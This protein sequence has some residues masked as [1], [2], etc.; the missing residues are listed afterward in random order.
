M[1][2]LLW[3]LDAVSFRGPELSW[4]KKTIHSGCWLLRWFEHLLYKFLNRTNR[5]KIPK[6]KHI[7]KFCPRLLKSNFQWLRRR[8]KPV[9]WKLS[10]TNQCCL[11]RD[12]QGHP[13]Q[14]RRSCQL[15]RCQAKTNWT[16]I[17]WIIDWLKKRETIKKS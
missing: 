7:S 2:G 5:S 3:R 17:Y 1:Y 8:W 9:G 14:A 10:S 4:W 15:D 12:F 6:I 13:R 11:I 16:W